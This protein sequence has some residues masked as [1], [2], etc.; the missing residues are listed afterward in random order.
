VRTGDPYPNEWK[1]VE[2]T[3]A[4]ARRWEIVREWVAKNIT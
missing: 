3:H 4:A 2:I 1:R